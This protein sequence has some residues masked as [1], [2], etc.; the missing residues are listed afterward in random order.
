M[1][2]KLEGSKELGGKIRELREKTG[3]TLSQLAKDT[4]IS[5]SYLSQIER[6]E[7]N[8]PTVE[9]LGRISNALGIDLV[10]RGSPSRNESRA[11]V[12][13]SPF[14]VEDLEGTTEG[15]LRNPTVQLLAKALND[16]KTPENYKKLLERQIMGLISA[17]KEE[18][19]SSEQ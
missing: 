7:V 17:L 10:V 13:A 18:L 15:A 3:K 11:L 4:G 12:Y 16:S 9:V 19:Q 1:K 5:K 6:A 8:N 2:I 14:T